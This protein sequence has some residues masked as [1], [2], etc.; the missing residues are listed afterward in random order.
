MRTKA[1][2]ATLPG[3]RG[4]KDSTATVVKSSYGAVF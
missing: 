4:K 1:S 2:F 3:L